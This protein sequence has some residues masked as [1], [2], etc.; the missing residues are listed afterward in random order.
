MYNKTC[1]LTTTNS[2][3]HKTCIRK[4]GIHLIYN[5]N[6]HCL[7]ICE[8]R[9]RSFLTKW[10]TEQYG[11]CDNFLPLLLKYKGMRHTILRP[12]YKRDSSSSTFNISSPN[13]NLPLMLLL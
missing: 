7:S 11:L 10:C 3:D 12:Q 13:L 9:L 6:V 1:I 4:R 8:Y 2:F 5:D